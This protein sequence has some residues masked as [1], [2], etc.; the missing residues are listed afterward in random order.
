[1]SRRRLSKHNG[2]RTMRQREVTTIKKK[3]IYNNQYSMGTQSFHVDTLASHACVF[4]HYIGIY[5]VYYICY[6]VRQSD[7]RDETYAMK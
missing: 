4:I 3:Y 6:I 1:M 7:G 2:K 5:I